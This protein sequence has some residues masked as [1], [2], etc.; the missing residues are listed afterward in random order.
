MLATNK[1][2]W[3]YTS[4]L[5]ICGFFLFLEWLYPVKEITET[6]NLTVFIIYAIFCFCI[7]MLQVNWMLSF[8]LKG[9]GLFIIIHQLFFNQSILSTLWVNQLFA[10]FVFNIQSLFCSHWYEV[11]S[12]FRCLLFFFLIWLL[13]F[14]FH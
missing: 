6:N 8:I 14:L 4:I 7:S 1:I 12:L 10:E 9:S 3:F 5:Y 2:S 11:T 13:I